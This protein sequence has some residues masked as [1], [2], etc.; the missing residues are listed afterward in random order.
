MSPSSGRQAKVFPNQIYFK[1]ENFQ[2]IIIINQIIIIIIIASILVH[3]HHG[4]TNQVF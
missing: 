3:V 1:N 2:Q 4:F